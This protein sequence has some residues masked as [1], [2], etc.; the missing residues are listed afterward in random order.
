VRPTPTRTADIEVFTDFACPWC[1]ITI[2]RLHT[3]LQGLPDD[4]RAEISWRPF[5]LDRETAQAALTS[6]ENQR[7]LATIGPGEGIRF[8]FDRL[9]AV[10]H[11]FEAHRLVWLAARD[12]LRGEVVA[13]LVDRIYR[14]YFAEGRDIGNR[15][16]LTALTR[17]AGLDAVRVAEQL[18]SPAGVL[19]VRALGRRALALGIETPPFLLINNTLGIRG[20]RSSAFLREKIA[21]GSWFGHHP[22]NSA[23][24]TTAAAAAAAAAERAIDSVLADSFPAS[25]APPWTLGVSE[26][27]PQTDRSKKRR[28]A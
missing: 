3:A 5:P 17:E 14:A 2:R 11:T 28:L 27:T 23:P 6:E 4:V 18:A 12:G 7:F 9:A 16:A 25:D 26:H 10:P 22:P 1:Y 13:D 21:G 15:A 24:E 20:T 19:E 8:A